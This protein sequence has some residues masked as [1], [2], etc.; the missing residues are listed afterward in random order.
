MF[1]YSGKLNWGT[2]AKDELFIVI[3]PDGT[4][5]RGDSVYL[6]SQWTKDAAGVKK[7]NWFDTKVVTNVTKTEDG[8]DMIEMSHNFYTY[9]ITTKQA[10]G[11]LDITM[12]NPTNSKSYMTLDRVYQSQGEL[13]ATDSFRIWTGKLDWPEYASNEPILVLVPEGVGAGK[14]VLA[15]WQWTEDAEKKPKVTF[16]INTVQRA[17]NGP[18][19]PLKFD[20]DGPPYSLCCI[21]DEGTA[22]L[23]VQMKGP[24]GD[25]ELG[26]LTQAVSKQSHSHEM[27]PPEPPMEK[28]ELSVCY[29]QT[30]AALPRIQT[31]MPFPRDLVQTLTHTA[32]FVDQAGYLAKYATEACIRRPYRFNVL[33]K[34][35]HGL[36]EQVEKCN[37]Q[38]R[39]LNSK[40]SE[41]TDENKV[42]KS[43]S[44]D[45]EKKLSDAR[46]EYV[47]KEAELTK[48]I[49]DL[50]KTISNDRDHDAADHKAL[51]D[52]HRMIAEEQAAK[53][54]LQKRLDETEIALAAAQA[55]VQQLSAQ[56]SELNSEVSHLRG[57]LDVEIAHNKELDKSNNE[58]NQ[59]VAKLESDLTSTQKQLART[60]E[61]LEQVRAESDDKDKIIEG[62]EAGM[63]AI[64]KD[65][66]AKKKAVEELKKKTDATIQDLEAKLASSTGGSA[67]QPP[68][69]SIFPFKQITPTPLKQSIAKHES[70]ST[71]AR[72]S[73]WIGTMANRGH[74]FNTLDDAPETAKL[75][76]LRI[77]SD[78]NWISGFTVDWTDGSSKSYGVLHG[79]SVHTISQ[80]P[81]RPIVAVN[82]VTD[83]FGPRLPYQTLANMTFFGFDKSNGYQQVDEYIAPHAHDRWT[84]AVARTSFAPALDGTWALRGVYG[85]YDGCIDA[86]G[87]VW[88]IEK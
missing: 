31:Q 66:D 57:Q 63:V 49:Q 88:G 74:F 59:K 33:D 34:S 65:R 75:K 16:S 29:P 50:Q 37:K 5:R 28:S 54:K 46:D 52:A 11:K 21:R 78:G 4:A 55:R 15:F 70:K 44:A 86:I 42:E 22:K 9:V 41:L 67:W 76:T 39:D 60:Q 80:M 79:S 68:N 14:P 27:T 48:Q 6:F 51:D 18:G 56:I 71:W 47:K 40:I 35:F 30:E 83:N 64:K 85:Y 25:K 43:K 12:S 10:Y 77:H 7:P 17:E 23:T 19:E 73:P 72:L 36:R 26:D 24:E 53:A 32:S 1:V 38:I 62:L 13:S 82:V 3:L 81:D 84:T 61:D 8:E 69:D 58:L 2:S 45:L 87:F 20:F